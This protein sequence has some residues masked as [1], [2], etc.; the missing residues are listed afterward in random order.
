MGRMT[1]EE[2]RIYAIKKS[3]R[4]EI[5]SLNLHSFGSVKCRDLRENFLKIEK[6][7]EEIIIELNKDLKDG[8]DKQ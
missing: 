3:K 8:K 4:K 7:I 6:K 1:D 5:K 2:R